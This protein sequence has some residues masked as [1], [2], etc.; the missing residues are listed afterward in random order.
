MYTY[1]YGK[2]LRLCRQLHMFF[3]YTGFS[4]FVSLDKTCSWESRESCGTYLFRFQKFESGVH[5]HGSQILHATSTGVKARSLV[6]TDPAS[7]EIY[8]LP[9]P[10]ALPIS[11]A[12]RLLPPSAP[13]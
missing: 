12:A 13:P 10:Y 5:D 11:A 7:P 1:Q 8:T 6:L 4:A 9:L 3:A 2:E